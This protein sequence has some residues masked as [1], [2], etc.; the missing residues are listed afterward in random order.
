M[1]AIVRFDST[2]KSTHTC[3]E[4][5]G[6]FSWSSRI[7]CR[8][9]HVRHFVCIQMKVVLLLLLVMLLMLLKLQ[10]KNAT[11]FSLSNNDPN[12]LRLLQTLKSNS[13]N[14][15]MPHTHR[16]RERNSKNSI[17]F[18]KP[19]WVLIS[20]CW[21]LFVFVCSFSF[22]NCFYLNYGMICEFPKWV[23]AWNVYVQWNCHLLFRLNICFT[24]IPVEKNLSKKLIFFEKRDIFC[25]IGHKNCD[26][27]I[28][29]N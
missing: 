4:S 22:R 18:R 8:E 26:S 29:W 6:N 10:L 11:F 7:I 24:R 14:Q 3:I 9:F 23:N 16:E 19:K 27:H 25:C 21:L 5:N 2:R 1:C 15:Q 28:Y 13:I 17:D 12:P 20:I